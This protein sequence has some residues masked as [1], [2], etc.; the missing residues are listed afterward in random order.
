MYASRTASPHDDSEEDE[1]DSSV[2]DCASSDLPP[3]PVFMGPATNSEP[4]KASR[5]RPRKDPPMLIPQIAKPVLNTSPT[6]KPKHVLLHLDKEVPISRVRTISKTPLK[7]AKSCE[8]ILLESD[9]STVF[10]DEDDEDEDEQDITTKLNP[11]KL[12]LSLPPVIEKKSYVPNKQITT[13]K[14]SQLAAVNAQLKHSQNQ[15]QNKINPKEPSIPNLERE[16]IKPTI[17]RSSSPYSKPPVLKVENS[18]DL[19]GR[20]N[21]QSSPH[22]PSLPLQRNETSH[23]S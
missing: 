12:P 11:P 7:G 10:S 5:G 8:V 13:K 16:E 3:P 23:S 6:E 17:E 2:S 18:S 15:H 22:P 21:R 4:V 1:S 9:D 20:D 14:A 19:S